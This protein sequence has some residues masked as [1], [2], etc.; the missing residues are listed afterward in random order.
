MDQLRE[1]IKRPLVVGIIGF[2]IGAIFGLVVLGW[3]LFPVE[4][5]NALP[6]HLSPSAKVEYLRMTIEA[7]GQ[8]G[9]LQKALTRFNALGD[10]AEETLATIIQDPQE[11]SND[12]IQNFKSY[13]SSGEVTP[14]TTSEAETPLP[15]EESKEEEGGVR[16]VLLILIPILCVIVLVLGAVLF[17][18]FVLRGRM[19]AG[20]K[21]SQETTYDETPDYL[22][23]E[24][25]YEPGNEPPIAQ[26]MASYNLGDD[27][28][29]DSFSIESPSGEFLGECGV[30][31]SEAIGV[32]EPKKVTAFE[33]WLFDKNDIQTITKVLMSTHAYNDEMISQRLEAK[34]EPVLSQPGEE[35]LLETQTLSLVARVVD[36]GYLEGAAP[37]QSSFD[38]LVVELMAWSK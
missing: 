19:A 33:I 21:E 10:S 34:G 37:S 24:E 35:I 38:H 36:M 15:T 20:T 7:Y 2:I 27:L 5:V 12:L 3:Q 18:I 29:D 32:G 13:V 8:N 30:G 23:E 4:W 22:E 31:I 17:Y 26:F 11:L 16:N 6:E 25:Y 14:I 9:D 28:F 1:Q